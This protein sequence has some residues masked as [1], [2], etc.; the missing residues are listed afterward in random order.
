MNEKGGR[1]TAT[2]DLSKRLMPSYFFKAT[3]I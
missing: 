3:K 2:P 1:I